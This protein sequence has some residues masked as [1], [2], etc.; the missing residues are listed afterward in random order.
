MKTIGLIGGMSWESTAMY[1]SLLNQGIKSQLGGF[2][3]AKCIINSV[4]F[5]I[6]EAL[7]RKNDWD[8]LN[9]I[10]A[11][12][13]KQ[14]ENAGADVILLCTNTMHLC[15][16]AIQKNVSIPFLHIAEATSIKIREQQL[17]KVAL[18]GTKFTMEKDFYKKTLQAYG[19]EAIIPNDEDK[20]RIHHII[21]NELVLGKINDQSRE[22]CINIIKDLEHK[23]VE[24]VILG[25]TELP[26]LISSEDVTI[27]I[28]DTT[29]IHVEA[30][31]TF[32]LQ[33]N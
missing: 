3:S 25:C 7:Q 4:D 30:G 27:P 33:N 11:A 18:L 19:I 13:A 24:G 15:S 17:K 14:L 23:G 20:E 32:A 22:K 8:T 6:I 21:F 16:D 5:A 2:H 29:Q 28:F 12:S 10:M 1:Y 26:L 31:I 9:T